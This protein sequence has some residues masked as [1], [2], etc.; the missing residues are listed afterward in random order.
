MVRSGPLCGHSRGPFLR[1]AFAFAAFHECML[2]ATPK[3][4]PINFNL[5]LWGAVDRLTVIAVA[6]TVVLIV[7][8]SIWRR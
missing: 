8:L 3:T 2:K 5:G 1:Q 6:V 7:A 4:D